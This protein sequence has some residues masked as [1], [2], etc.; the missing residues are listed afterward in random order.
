[1]KLFI[2]NM[3]CDRCTLVVR[4]VLSE[5]GVE[6]VRVKLGE[7]DLGDQVMAGD[8]LQE[9]RKRIESLGFGLISDR[10]SQLIENIKKQLIA[11]V[12][13]GRYRENAPV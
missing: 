3:V 5:L 10:K 9:F 13:A 7:V 8:Q 6:P 11:L 1:M 2:K 4:N 12:G